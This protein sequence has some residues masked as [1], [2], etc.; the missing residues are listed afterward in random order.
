MP[1]DLPKGGAERVPGRGVRV[2]GTNGVA[3]HPDAENPQSLSRRFLRVPPRVGEHREPERTVGEQLAAPARHRRPVRLEQRAVRLADADATVDLRKRLFEQGAAREA[4]RR[5]RSDPEFVPRVCAPPLMQPT[6][7]RANALRPRAG[8]SSR[9]G[10]RAD[11]ASAARER[12]VFHRSSNSISVVPS[13]GRAV[14]THG[15]AEAC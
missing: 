2:R 3:D 10:P 9:A 6:R 7:P 12:C 13:R 5:C 1:A 15:V 4:R 11:R 14:A 8:S